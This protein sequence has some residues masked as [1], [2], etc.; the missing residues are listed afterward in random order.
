MLM[1][2]KKRVP[3]FDSSVWHVEEPD[4]LIQV[5]G[6]KFKNPS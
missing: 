3:A 6:D 4:N 5:N 1:H 2:I